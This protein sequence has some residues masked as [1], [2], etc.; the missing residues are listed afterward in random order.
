MNADILLAS[1][2]PPNVVLIGLFILFGLPIFA[3]TFFI[4]SAVLY[5]KKERK[6]ARFFAICGLLCTLVP[7]LFWL[8]FF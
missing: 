4:V 6:P 5:A 2:P 7:L 3:A 1:S 8:S